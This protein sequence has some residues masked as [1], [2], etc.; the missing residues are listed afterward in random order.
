MSQDNG[1]F[2]AKKIVG[3]CV[4][5]LHAK[6]ATTETAICGLRLIRDGLRSH[7]AFSEDELK[8]IVDLIEDL[9]LNAAGD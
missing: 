1:R 6:R 3:H 9:Q 2:D 8:P 5:L 7:Y 4:G